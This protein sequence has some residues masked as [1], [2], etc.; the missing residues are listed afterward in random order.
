MKRN[1][2]HRN[3]DNQPRANDMVESETARKYDVLAN[4]QA[5]LYKCKVRIIPYV[6]TWDGVVTNTTKS[7]LRT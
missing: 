3:R 7:T 2:N 1:F 5:A 6:M 4:E